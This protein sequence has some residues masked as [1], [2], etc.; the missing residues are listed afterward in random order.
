[1]K[2]RRSEHQARDYQEPGGREDGGQAAVEK[3][4]L[5][6]W[7]STL[8][9]LPCAALGLGSHVI[10]DTKHLARCSQAAINR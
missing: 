2:A 9:V 4:P 8:H 5:S 7:D 10:G 6:N 3:I 1:M